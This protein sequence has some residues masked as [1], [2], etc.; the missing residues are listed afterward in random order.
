MKA[1]ELG[2]EIGEK[3]YK[4]Y[5]C[6]SKH[7]LDMWAH[8]MWRCQEALANELPDSPYVHHREKYYM[9]GCG[10][11][12]LYAMKDIRGQLHIPKEMIIRKVLYQRRLRRKSKNY[13]G[14]K[15]WYFNVIATPRRK[16]GTT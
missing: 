15:V 16:K 8:Q 11:M 1:Y 7:A 2:T 9:S 10:G 13:K 14:S 3:T 4:G 6:V 5:V 12:A